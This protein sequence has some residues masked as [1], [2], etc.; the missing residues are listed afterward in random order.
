MIVLLDQAALVLDE[1]MVSQRSRTS[2]PN[3][4]SATLL[5]LTSG[6]GQKPNIASG[7]RHVRFRG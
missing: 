3:A 5:D 6:K 2:A 4:A 1:H 7:L